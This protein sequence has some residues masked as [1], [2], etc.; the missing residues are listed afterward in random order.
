MNAHDINQTFDLLALAQGD[1]KL[2]HKGAYYIGPCP[3]CGG[4]D[5]FNLKHTPNGWRWFCRGCGGEKY[6]TPIDYVMRRDNLDFKQ[7]LEQMGGKAYTP[8]PRPAQPIPTAPAIVLPVATWQA[9]RW[10]EVTRSTLSLEYDKP[11][12]IARDYLYARALEPATWLV[13]QFGFGLVYSRPAIV[14]PW[15]DAANTITA[16]KYRFI[17]DLAKR[18]PGRRFG[19]A[20]GSKPILFGLHLAGGQDTLLLCEG[21]FNAASITQVASDTIT[22]LDTLSFGSQSGGR[23]D[24]LRQVA[25]G[26]QRVIVWADDP[27]KANEIRLSLARPAEALCSPQIDG[28]KYDANALLKNGYLADFLRETIQTP[29]NAQ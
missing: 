4:R 19:M 26:Y 25:D 18:D 15:W 9:Q 23:A 14:I 21:E 13:Y 28:T 16:V 29:T 3:F 7:A 10:Q 1:A 11:A 17:D 5:R 12:Q 22:G 6:H 27:E 24:F 8:T 20:E 2:N